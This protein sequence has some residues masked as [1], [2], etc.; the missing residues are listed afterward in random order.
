MPIIRQQLGHTSLAT[1][2]RYPDHIP[3]ADWSK[4]CSGVSSTFGGRPG[5]NGLDRIT[6]VAG[7]P[8]P[9]FARA[10]G[11]PG[12]E[13]TLRTYRFA[14]STHAATDPWSVE[15]RIRCGSGA[16]DGVRRW[17]RGAPIRRR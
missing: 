9:K 14:L 7:F 17:R 6:E 13:G 5:G 3:R 4:R 11:A 2:Q 1:T 15:T 8:L 10:G 16:G 12:S